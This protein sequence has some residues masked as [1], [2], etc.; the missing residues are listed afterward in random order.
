MPLGIAGAGLATTISIVVAIILMV[1]YFV[2]L[3]HYVGFDASL[4]RPR[5]AAWKRILAIGLPPGG[6]FALMFVYMAVIYWVIR[7]FGPEAQAGFGIGSRVMQA[8]FLPAMA[9]AWAVAPVA[10]QNVGARKHDRVRHTFRTAMG[11]LSGLMLLL[12]TLLQ[13]RPDVLVA[14]FSED[15]AVIAAGAGFLRIISWNFVA[16]GVV[17]ICS[18]MFQAIGHT[19]PALL[20][21]A[22]RIVTFAI[23]AV[24]L[25]RQPWF[26]LH[27]LWY[28]SVAT[29][30]LQAAASW[31]MLSIELP[32]KLTDD[33]AL[34]PSHAA[35]D[36]T[37]AL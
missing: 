28:T 22:T 10:G 21:S 12:T 32:R 35:L 34:A 24:W 11:T 1:A 13:W 20:A 6:E 4:I 9:I 30:F 29:V 7:G 27:H 37:A 31:L 15:P 17:F 26:E 2:R 5:A 18:G 33:P 3:E 16:S 25:S 19:V 8:I 36:A 14:F 23:P